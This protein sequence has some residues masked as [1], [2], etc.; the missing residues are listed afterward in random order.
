M[1]IA[2]AEIRNFRKI[3]KL[4][5]DFTNSL[6]EVREAS[7][8]AGPN[9]SGKT[10]ILDALAVCLGLG[11][12]LS[13]ARPDFQITPRI[14][15]R[16][17][18]ETRV[19]CWV[20]FAPAEIEAT[21]EIFKLAQEG[22]KIIPKAREVKVTW[23]YPDPNHRSK[24][25]FT[26]YEPESAWTLFKSRVKVARL[27]STRLLDWNWFQRVGGVFTFDQQRTGLGRTIPR[28]IWN[29]ING[30]SSG[31]GDGSGFGGGSG[32]GSGYSDGSGYGGGE[33]EHRSRRT[34][35][36]R[37]ILLALAVQSKFPAAGEA[38]TDQF[39]LIKER[40]D[41]LCA[42]HKLLGAMRDDLGELDLRFTDGFN[43]YFYEELSSGEEMLLLFLIRMVAEHIHQSVVLVDEL[44]LHQHPIW[45]RKLLHL[46]PKIGSNNQLI[47]T[48]H[49]PYLREVMSPE[50]VFDLGNLLGD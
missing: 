40:Y 15:R 17:E 14:V 10:T 43:E 18:L 28:D 23:V 44:E 45:Q 32:S 36:P 49:S 29:I 4:D 12:E 20:R 35:D 37:E 26:F 50:A 27:L 39:K 22:G 41:Q 8:I 5:L 19:T 38:Q 21:R 31:Y 11:T 34:S 13:Y 33:A 1:K 48:T 25:G 3:E 24:L 7:I 46:L 6:D 42:P 30:D 47:A 9:T 2:R 16:G